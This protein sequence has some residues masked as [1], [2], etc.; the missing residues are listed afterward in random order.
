MNTLGR[1]YQ[2][3][4]TRIQKIQDFADIVPQNDEVFFIHM[5]G[6]CQDYLKSVEYV[7]NTLSQN[8]Q[9][10]NKSY[11]R[12]NGLP[13]LTDYSDVNYYTDLFNRWNAGS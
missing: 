5:S 12:I 3:N 11:I 8:S 2:Y 9:N 4:K 1:I 7:D 13:K 10:E 6:V